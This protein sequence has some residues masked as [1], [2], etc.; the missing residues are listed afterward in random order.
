MS[1]ESSHPPAAPLPRRVHLIACGVLAIDLK[2][3]VKKLGIGPALTFLPGGLHNNPQ[4]LRRRLQEAIDAASA[5]GKSDLIAVGYGVCGQG[6][7]GLQ[8][9]DVPLAIPCVHDCIAL[10]LGSDRAYSEQFGRYPGTYYVSA[11]WVEEDVRPWSA[12]EEEPL[13]CRG[14]LACDMEWLKDQYGGDN[15]QAVEQFLSSWQRNYQ[16][17]AF[18]DTGENSNRRDR[19]AGMA[20]AMAEEF[21]WKYEELPG[22]HDL[23]TDLLTKQETT[24]G[25]LIVPPGHVTVYDGISRRLKAAPLHEAAAAAQPLSQWVIEG[26]QSHEPE[27]GTADGKARMGLGID[28]GGTYTDIVIYDCETHTVLQKAKSLTTKWDYS[29]GIDAALDQLDASRFAEVDLVSVSTT[30]ATNAIVEGRGQK[31]GL[32]LMPPYG[33]RDPENFLHDLIAL[34]DGQLEIDG[35]ELVPVNPEQVRQC[36]RHMLDRQNVQAFAVAGYASHANP[37][38]ELQ[39]LAAVREETNAVITCAHD[40]SGGLNYRIRAETAVLNARIVPCLDALL[41]KVRSTIRRRGLQAPLTVVKSDGSLMSLEAARQR[42]IETI[43]SGPAASVAGAIYLAGAP[44]AMVVDIGGTTTDTA[45]IRHG[46][47]ETSDDGATV[48]R[49]K[50]H[51]EALNMRTLGLGGDS[52]VAI[53]EGKLHIGPQRIAPIAWLAARDPR[54]REAL[55]WVE[56]HLDRFDVSSRGMEL[57]ALTPYEHRALQDEKEKRVV[58]RLKQRCFSVDELIQ[59]ENSMAEHLLPLDRL[60]ADH[61]IQRCGLTP[62]DLLHA[63]GSLRLWDIQASQCMC[64]LYARLLRLTRDGFIEQELNR[65]VRLLAV[66]LIKK[67]LAD[68][69]I[70]PEALE[71]C[72]AAMALISKALDGDNNTYSVRFK[73][74]NPVIGI[75]APA[76]FFLPQAAELLQAKAIIPEHADVA[77]AIGAITSLVRILRQVTIG[78]NEK[79]LYRLEGLPGT[80]TFGNVE[81]AQRFAVDR[82]TDTVRDLGRQA[83]TR[84]SR[85][86]I[87]IKDHMVALKDGQQLFIERSVEALLTGHPDLARLAAE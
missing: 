78:V 13:E 62:T 84:Q 70:D 29:I 46:A 28:A 82:L 17:A 12:Q 27:V 37:A 75:G 79:G 24:E 50:T 41:E 59:C 40:V 86:E 42:P 6:T 49:W 36:V 26:K 5:D 35:R 60:E 81:E 85:V 2:A 74:K 19:Y 83:G 73:L 8:A 54:I 20:K 67:Q 80:P 87:R 77:N 32:L 33:W 21:G 52:R 38:H 58:A 68:D 44:D 66:E 4:E 65:F 47:V 53:R 11:G 16:R 7:V 63:R 23:L 48:G 31:V 10:F 30:L 34:V 9:R 18:I 15:A 22:T 71:Q 51:V 76:H 56:Y 39:V 72:E 25:I 64:D 57:L 55:L 43:L 69:N 3:I 45:T 61:I 1:S 14:P